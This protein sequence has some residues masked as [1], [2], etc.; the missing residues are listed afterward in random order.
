MRMPH[1]GLVFVNTVLWEVFQWRKDL[2]TVLMV[3]RLAWAHLGRIGGRRLIW[4]ECQFCHLEKW[5]SKVWS[6]G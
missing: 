4:L 3:D 6:L 1:P 2:R 5:F